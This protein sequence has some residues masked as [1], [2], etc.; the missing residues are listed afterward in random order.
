ML[1]TSEG[2]N[3]INLANYFPN[4]RSYNSVV[5]FHKRLLRDTKEDK[6]KDI[7]KD[8]KSDKGKSKKKKTNI[9]IKHDKSQQFN[10]ETMNQQNYRYKTM[11]SAPHNNSVLDQTIRFAKNLVPLVL[12]KESVP[13][14][15]TI[16]STKKHRKRE[17]KPRE[18]SIERDVTYN[19]YTLK[20]PDEKKPKKSHK[21]NSY[22]ESIGVSSQNTLDDV[23]ININQSCS[24]SESTEVKFHKK[25]SN[26]YKVTS[27][28]SQKILIS[29]SF[30][31]LATESMGDC[32]RI[33]IHL[34]ND[35]DKNQFNESIQN[36]IINTIKDYLT[37]SVIN[38]NK[39]L[40]IDLKNV[41]KL[42]K[43]NSKKLDDILEK[44][45][46]I[47]KE[48]D[49]HAK[50][51]TEAAVPRAQSANKASRLEE[52]ERD[53][54]EVKE[55]QTSE[56]E[57]FSEEYNNLLKRRRNRGKSVVVAIEEKEKEGKDE[58][59]TDSL[60]C[61]EEIPGPMNATSI[62][63]LGVKPDRPNR[64][65]ARFCWTDADRKK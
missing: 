27:E 11:E 59:K 61:G 45:T 1:P 35:A 5:Y 39:D 44:L 46:C 7:K 65:P 48:I 51:T 30:E 53:I 32:N 40:N 31:A 19:K 52:L 37:H 10:S 6:P 58:N 26:L 41:Q 43:A 16:K 2:I 20:K 54:I 14:F 56:D 36:P 9:N 15:Y 25:A 8:E 17:K 55:H 21:D 63:Q 57:D 23:H 64:I 28:N 34:M 18:S 12:P 4:R 60:A 38:T 33:K 42:A 50:Q 3:G 29:N 49:T 22:R 24:F 62:S 47:Q 13:I